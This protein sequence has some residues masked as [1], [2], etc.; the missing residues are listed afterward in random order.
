VKGRFFK[1]SAIVLFLSASLLT[2]CGGGGGGTPATADTWVGTKQL[3]VAGVDTA[4]FSVAT[5]TSG[6]IFVAG[7]TKGG[8]DGNNLTGTTDFFVTEYDPSGVK[9]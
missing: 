7:V 2:A 8:L 6:N 9:Q 5:D 4:A 1:Y 3:G